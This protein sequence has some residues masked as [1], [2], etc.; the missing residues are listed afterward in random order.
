MRERYDGESG[1]ES[2][3][4]RNRKKEGWG[5]G[6][7][8]SDKTQVRNSKIGVAGRRRNL[9]PNIYLANL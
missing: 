9:N 1:K 6:G 8:A 7:M 5:A 4:E 3:D 2:T